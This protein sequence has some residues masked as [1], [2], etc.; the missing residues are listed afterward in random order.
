M[1]TAISSNWKTI[2]KIN[3][4]LTILYPSSTLFTKYYIEWISGQKKLASMPAG[5]GAVVAAPVAAG[6]GDAAAKR[7]LILL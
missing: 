6:G 5:G 1:M 7:K 4:I 2:W 3:L